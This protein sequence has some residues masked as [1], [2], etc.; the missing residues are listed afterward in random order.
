MTLTPDKSTRDAIEAYLRARRAELRKG[1]WKRQTR[2]N[3]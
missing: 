3:Q 1:P 2:S